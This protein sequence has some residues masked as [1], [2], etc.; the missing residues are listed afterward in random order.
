MLAM[1]ATEAARQI[2]AQAETISGYPVHVME[3]ATLRTLSTVTMARGG[4]QFHIVRYNPSTTRQPEYLV[5]FQCGFII[6]AFEPPPDKRFDI[7]DS[8]R[9]R[10]ESASLITQHLRKKG[11]LPLP[12]EAISNLQQQ[13]LSGLIIQLRSMPVGMR[14]DLGLFYDFPALREQ[15][16]QS[17]LRQLQ[18]NS[19]S[20][21]P[22]IAEFSPP[23]IRKANVT[24]NAAFADLWAKLLDEPQLALPYEAAGYQSNMLELLNISQ[25]IPDEPSRDIELIDAWGKQLGIDRWYEWIPRAN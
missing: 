24:M 10:R 6:R 9:G 17:A 15:Q 12:Q 23:L 22:Q 20:L 4:S 1:T 14:I 19:Q 2:R 25:R 11:K 3:D 5:S 8:E 13:M 7:T 18:E 16:R 21:L